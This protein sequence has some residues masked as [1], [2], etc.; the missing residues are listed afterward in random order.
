[1]PDEGFGD[2]VDLESLLPLLYSESERGCVLIAAAYLDD[3]LQKALRAGFQSLSGIRKEDLDFLL[4]KRPMP[5]LQSLALRTLV[6]YAIGL[7]DLPTR[8]ALDA[9]RD[10]RNDAAHLDKPVKFD[11]YD[12][13]A[14][15]NA[16]DARIL[17]LADCP[18]F[19]DRFI[20][21]VLLLG[22]RLLCVG[23]H[24]REGKSYE[25]WRDE[26][27]LR[28]Q[29]RLAQQLGQSAV[30]PPTSESETENK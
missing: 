2:Q 11:D 9:I 8:Q 27:F 24:P 21:M 15:A 13:Q 10:M 28:E 12:W 4:T 14:L 7:I 23:R 29:I 5:P 19:R 6:A 22:H 30:A 26:Q 1:M 18:T 20:W 16:C 3:L 25:T 17:D